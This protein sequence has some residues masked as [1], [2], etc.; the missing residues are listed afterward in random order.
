MAARDFS[1][2]GMGSAA[3]LT[4]GVSFYD[5]DDAE[6]EVWAAWFW[7]ALPAITGSG[8]VTLDDATSAGA[9]SP[10]VVGSGA[11]TMDAA[12]SAGS[13]TSGASTG[14]RRARPGGRQRFPSR[15]MSPERRR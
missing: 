11:V 3:R 13:G 7:G 5:Q 4:R 9:G 15:G 6:K 8:A 10:V 14:V 1:T 2:A 12:T